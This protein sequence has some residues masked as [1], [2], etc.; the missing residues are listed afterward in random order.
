MKIELEPTG[1]F[2]DV[3]GVRT[4]IWEG[5]TDQGVPVKAWIAMISP[6]TRDEAANA[7][8]AR[9]LR[10]VKGELHAHAY[11]LRLFID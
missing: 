7:L 6:Q 1:T 2:Q 8:F 9:E 10:E 4:R 3:N 11:D 5:K